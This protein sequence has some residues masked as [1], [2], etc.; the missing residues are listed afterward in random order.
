MGLTVPLT[1]LVMVSRNSN[2]F[3][4]LVA[5]Q[6]LNHSLVI[7]FF[8]GG[9]LQSHNPACMCTKVDISYGPKSHLHVW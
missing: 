3:K 9:F 4:V 8:G 5:E 2:G 1:V 7:H 6:K